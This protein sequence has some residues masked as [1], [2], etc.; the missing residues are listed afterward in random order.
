MGV[1]LCFKEALLLQRRIHG[2]VGVLSLFH[3][4]ALL[5]TAKDSWHSGSVSLLYEAL[6]LQ[7]RIRGIVG[8]FLCF[9]RLYCVWYIIC[10]ECYVCGVL[11]VWCAMCVVCYVC[12][13]LY[14]WCAICVVC[15]VCGVLC[16]WCVSVRCVSVRCV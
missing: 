14:V 1:F 10:M 15:Y 3:A 6:L 4:Q 13:V 8:V 5:A 11:C 16:V 12:G 7:R 9:M 2:I